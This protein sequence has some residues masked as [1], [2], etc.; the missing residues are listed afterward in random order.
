MA[1]L[2]T[3]SVIEAEQ[4]YMSIRLQSYGLT[5]AIADQPVALS[6][7]IQVG[8]TLP[9]ETGHD[10]LASAV[11]SLYYTHPEL[12]LP[13]HQV[14]LYY[15]PEQSVLVPESLH[16]EADASAWIEIVGGLEREP[17]QVLS[18]A[19]PSE[20]KVMVSA[21][22][23]PLYQYLKRTHLQLRAIPYIAP[24]L[25]HLRPESRQHIGRTLVVSLRPEG[26]DCALLRSGDT[27][28]LNTY[29][30]VSPHDL[31]ACASEAVYYILS[32]SQS[33]GLDLLNDPLLL[34]KQ[35]LCPEGYSLADLVRR[36]L[37]RRIKQI[38]LID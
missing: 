32:L 6:E 21:W 37:V 30:W 15:I 20:R 1:L 23:A 35:E 34:S 31:D 3:H 10:T 33:A 17:M 2:T 25:E 19:L 38:R 26:M 7:L 5:F 14:Y 8:H 4:K 18:Y 27:E 12:S 24:L 11:Q 13:Y 9:L 28:M 29:R 16:S 22:D 36:Q